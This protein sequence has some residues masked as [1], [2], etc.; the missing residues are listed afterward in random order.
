MLQFS[1]LFERAWASPV[2]KRQ[3]INGLKK[4][5]NENQNKV[6]MIKASKPAAEAAKKQLI[7]YRKKFIKKDID[8]AK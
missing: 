7:D 1:E 8:M 6:N 3:F 2:A 4:F 5:K